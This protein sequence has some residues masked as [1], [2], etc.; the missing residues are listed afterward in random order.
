MF[1]A[2]REQSVEECIVNKTTVAMVELLWKVADL[3]QLTLS[4]AI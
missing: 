1:G 3:R 4:W 2:E